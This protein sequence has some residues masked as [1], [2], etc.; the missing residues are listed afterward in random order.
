VSDSTSCTDWDLCLNHRGVPN[1]LD[2][3]G[4]DDA[5]CCCKTDGKAGSQEFCCGVPD[6]PT[7][8]GA[9]CEGKDVATCSAPFFEA[10]D[11]ATKNKNVFAK[12]DPTAPPNSADFKDCMVYYKCVKNAYGPLFKQCCDCIS[13]YAQ[14]FDP[15]LAIDCEDPGDGDDDETTTKHKRV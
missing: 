14:T 5:Q 8:N 9:K 15:D 13:Y 1:W 11:C 6:A 4:D 12:C 3:A 2:A 7:P 10:V